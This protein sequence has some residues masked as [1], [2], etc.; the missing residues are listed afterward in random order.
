[1]S[2]NLMES[3]LRVYFSHPIP[4]FFL[5]SN[6]TIIHIFFMCYTIL[7]FAPEFMF[8]SNIFFYSSILLIM[9]FRGAFSLFFTGR[10]TTSGGSYDTI[11]IYL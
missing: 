3:F 6:Q 10:E 7:Y 9:C 2:S 11:Y 8:E 4:A 5:L 1:M